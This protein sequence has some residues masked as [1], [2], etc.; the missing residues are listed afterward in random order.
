MELEREGRAE[1]KTDIIEKEKM[2]ESWI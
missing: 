1:G 2:A